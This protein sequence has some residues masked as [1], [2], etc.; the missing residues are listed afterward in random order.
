MY[1][2]IGKIKAAPGQRDTLAGL[3]AARCGCPAAWLFG[4]GDDHA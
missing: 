3:A 1:G 2:L 4:G